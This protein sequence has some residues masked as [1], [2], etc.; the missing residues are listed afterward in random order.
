MTV[1][2]L[3]EEFD[4]S[5]D[6]M[7][8]ALRSHEV[9][10]HRVDLGWFPVRLSIAAELCGPHW[11]GHL[12]TPQ[13]RIE[14]AD[15]RSVWYRSPTAFRFSPELSTAERHHAFTE[16]KFGVGG[17]V[18]SLEVLWVNHPS[19]M[20]DA[21][22]KPMQLATAARCGLAVPSTL[23]SNDA[24]VVRHFVKQGGRDVVTKMFGAN[25][26]VE[27]GTR[28]ITYTRLMTGD[29][30]DDLR[31]I[32]QT[33]HQ[34]QQ[35]VPKRHDVRLIAIGEHRF[36]FAIHTDSSAARVDF[37]ADYESHRYEQIDIPSDVAEGVAA[38]MRSLGLVY[39]ALDF[40][41]TPDDDW[42]F[43]EINPGGQYG[44]LEP[45]TGAPLTETLADLLAKG[46][47]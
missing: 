2:I 4:V 26:I 17:V 14:L 29:D 10:V 30:L 28:K 7:V 32:E 11:V 23:V 35:W 46:S 25:H 34:F 33:A 42:V 6:L 12:L 3:A 13:R 37:R 1:L 16:A 19:R 8:R 38:L 20:A 24:A 5:A 31:G 45:P 44:W 36:G 22:Y 43:L 41:V 27:D 15:L 18:A 9:D 39:G 47:S 40:V 21:C